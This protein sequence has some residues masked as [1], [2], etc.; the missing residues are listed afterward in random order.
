MTRTRTLGT[1]ACAAVLALSLV[2]CGGDDKDKG[3]SKALS[4]TEFKDQANKLCAEASKDTESFGT[5]ITETSSDADVT[6]AIDKTVA[7]NKELIDAI[8]D[9]EAPDDLSDDVDS[10]LDSVEAGIEE[11]DKISSIADLTSIDTSAGPFAEADAKAKA[12][13]LDTC[14]E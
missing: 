5:G 9:L 10:M 4:A 11:L 6:E 14:A 2:G 1:V 13:G 12:L 3:D 8:D 7:R